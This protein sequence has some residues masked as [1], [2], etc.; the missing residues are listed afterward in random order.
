MDT[1]DLHL[2]VSSSIHASSH[3]HHLGLFQDA[4]S[5]HYGAYVDLRD[6]KLALLRTYAPGFNWDLR[7]VRNPD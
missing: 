2:T 7:H 1:L 5:A 4:V 6:F 3:H